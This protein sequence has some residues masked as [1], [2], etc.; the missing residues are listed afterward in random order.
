MTNDF[1]PVDFH[2]HTVLSPC[3]AKSGVKGE[4]GTYVGRARELGWRELCI[5]DHVVEDDRLPWLPAFYRGCTERLVRETRELAAKL[6][7][8]IQVLVGVEADMIDGDRIGASA[9]MA[10]RVTHLILPPNHFHMR[11][12][13]Q[14]PTDSPTD[15]GRHAP[16]HMLAVASLPWVDIMAH[17]FVV[18]R[19]DLPPIGEYL[20]TVPTDDWATM[21][22]RMVENGMALEINLHC[23][24]N[25]QYFG[26][27]GHL[28][29]MAVD[30]GVV[31]SYGSDAHN[32]CD[33]GLFRRDVLPQI[34]PLGFTADHFAAP[35]L[36]RAKRRRAA[37]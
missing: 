20:P 12:H 28:F 24:R 7:G 9:A 27:T 23:A 33:L 25:P 26:A 11:E 16:K 8:D 31:L 19:D 2:I 34:V 18:F 3:A 30:L 36:F 13:V 37:G 1:A 15:V 35:E 6:D 32:V 29:Q 14:P 21:F 4:L 10:R 17:P 22:K 5:T